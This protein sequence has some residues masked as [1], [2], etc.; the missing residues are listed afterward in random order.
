MEGQLLIHTESR[1][2]QSHSGFDEEILP[3]AR[4]LNERVAKTAAEKT[5]KKVV[6]TPEVG[7]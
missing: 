2:S 5:A 3:P 1:L 7:E 4:P 6:E